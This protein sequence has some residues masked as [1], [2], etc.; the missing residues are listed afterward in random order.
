MF[1]G[2][3]GPIPNFPISL[4]INGV[5]YNGIM[6]AQKNF[7]NEVTSQEISYAKN[8]TLKRPELYKYY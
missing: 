3:S 4:D 5:M 2:K 8:L 7:G 1:L 6:F